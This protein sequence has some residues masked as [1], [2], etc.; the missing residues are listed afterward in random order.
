MEINFENQN[1]ESEVFNKD[2]FPTP[3]EVIERMLNGKDLYDKYILEPSAGSGNIVRYCKEAGA[4]EV[5]AYEKMPKLRKMIENEC[6]LLG[7]DFLK[8]TPE[9]VS[10]V[11]M[12]VMNPPFSK[13]ED[14]ILKAWEIAPEGCEIIA[15][16]N[17]SII[18][19]YWHQSL[20]N[21][22]QIKLSEIIEENG[23][24]YELGQVFKNA[25]RKTN[26]Y[27]SV[28]ELH[29]PYKEGE[30]EFDSYFSYD[31]NVEDIP[32]EA[33]LV[34]YDFVRDCV[35]RYVDAVKEY[36]KVMEQA[37]KINNLTSLVGNCPIGFGA[38]WKTE[39]HYTQ[40]TREVFKKTLQKTSWFW[41]FDK[42]KLD[43]YITSGVKEDLNKFIEKQSD[44]P[45]TMKNIYRMIEIII[46]THESRM[47]KVIIEAFDDI[48]SFSADNSTAGEKWKTN[49]DYMINKRF[50]IPY[51][52]EYREWD[53]GKL[54]LRYDAYRS[55]IEDV[56]KALNYIMGYTHESWNTC[57]S[58]KINDRR[59]N[60]GETFRWNHFKVK[61]FKKGTM[62]FEFIDENVWAKFNQE[63]A[64]IRGWNLPKTTTKH[65]KNEFN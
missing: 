6:V 56:N 41:L 47:K 61:G 49:S 40:I 25:E 23:K 28:I 5:Y 43:K 2:F 19:D 13:D 21:E 26:V 9:D 58:S 36:N 38:F 62:H 7:D 24:T 33:G 17:S 51:M 34:T 57:L 44:V 39:K 31:E 48:C 27:V 11:D 59:P 3:K 42:F 32:T 4:K 16:C 10:H 52:T 1:T 35:N 29:K 30:Q 18:V 64:K 22:K 65:C 15:L 63:V 45:F 54:N 55:K 37:E 20:Y 8:A 60:Y 14:H 50:I 12:I 53:D 46:G